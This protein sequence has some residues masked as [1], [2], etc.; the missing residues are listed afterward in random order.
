M[1]AGS[2]LSLGPGLSF[3]HTVPVHFHSSR[4]GDFNVNKMRR[5]FCFKPTADVLALIPKYDPCLSLLA[6]PTQLCP[7][8][9]SGS[10]AGFL[11]VPKHWGSSRARS[12]AL[13]QHPPRAGSSHHSPAV[14][15][16]VA[17]PAT[18]TPPCDILFTAGIP[19]RICDLNPWHQRP[20]SLSVSSTGTG[21]F[22]FLSPPIASRPRKCL[23]QSYQ[24][25]AKQTKVHY[26]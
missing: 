4:L 16:G 3:P 15:P 26:V 5:L 18:S 25:V 7:S 19:I 12:P 14:P 8:F 21:A 13:P 11:L 20:P 9:T 6:Q 23:A 1:G 17:L 10:H 22:A 2:A 24:L